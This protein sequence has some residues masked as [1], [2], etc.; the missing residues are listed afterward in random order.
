M[1]QLTMRLT[2]ESG[3]SSRAAETNSFPYFEVNCFLI[4]TSS[5][6]SEHLGAAN[7]TLVTAS[8]RSMGQVLQKVIG[9]KVNKGKN[10][11]GKV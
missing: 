4:S 2:P 11:E 8:F 7:N 10:N 9:Q 3:L 5:D 1:S 6:I